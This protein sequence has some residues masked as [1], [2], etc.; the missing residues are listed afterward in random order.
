MA[1]TLFSV[2]GEHRKEPQRLLL[3]GDDG[4]FYAFT[5]N[6]TKPTM[7]KPSDEWRIDQQGAETPLG[8]KSDDIG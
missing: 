8:R 6:L 3:L 7:V 5:A 4:H 2:V 1:T